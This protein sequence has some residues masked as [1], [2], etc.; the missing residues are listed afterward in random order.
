MSTI[1]S[2]RRN[3]AKAYSKPT[4]ST[5][6]GVKVRSKL[7][8]Q[9]ADDLTQKG[10]TYSYEEE[11]LTYAVPATQHVY[12]PDFKLPNCD[13]YLEVKGY[14]DAETRKKML[15]IARSN[16]FVDIRFVFQRDNPIRKGSKTKYSDWARKN[17]FKW[18]IGKVPES[19]LNENTAN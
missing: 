6:T 19:W 4:I 8:K 18:A 7:E 10:A 16:P 13:W 11:S 15:Y 9:V 12:T 2:A 14:L 1:R 3:K 17:G 5:K